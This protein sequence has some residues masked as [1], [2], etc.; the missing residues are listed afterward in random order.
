[1]MRYLYQL[2]AAVGLAL[3]LIPAIL[4]YTDTM[5]IDQMKIY[6]FVGSMLWFAGAIPWL[7]KKKK[8]A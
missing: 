5:A 8:Q 3:V 7:G 2:L 4:H 1:M 6:M